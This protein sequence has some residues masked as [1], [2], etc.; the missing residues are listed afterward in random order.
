M[1]EHPTAQRASHGRCTTPSTA[2]HL[3][4]CA[5]FLQDMSPGDMP[6][7]TSV[8]F[9]EVDLRRA[10]NRIVFY[11]ERGTVTLVGSRDLNTLPG[12]AEEV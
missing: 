8:W 9:A 11:N 4:A 7:E 5:E 6:S 3:M 12:F 10:A 2:L 1:L